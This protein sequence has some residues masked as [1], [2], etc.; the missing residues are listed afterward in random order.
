MEFLCGR[1]RDQ[2]PGRLD[3]TIVPMPWPVFGFPT[4][5]HLPAQP[6]VVN[7]RR[8]GQASAVVLGVLIAHGWLIGPPQR[9]LGRVPTSTQAIQ[10]VT[11]PAA[12]A[13]KPAPE[14]TPAPA[15][16]PAPPRPR[17]A[18]PKTPTPP[19]E[20]VTPPVP[21]P[22]P[23][24]PIDWAA[25]PPPPDPV[26]GSVVIPNEGIEADP[27]APTPGTVAGQQE[28]NGGRPP[29]YTTRR[30][31][32]AS[33]R[34]DYRVERGDDA[35]HAQLSY[36]LRTGGVFF[37]HLV[38]EAKGKQLV[39]QTSRGFFNS[40][41]FAPQR[42]TERLRGVDVS[43]VNF[44]RDQGVITFS[45]ST[46]AY[47]LYPG[48]QDR[49]S[50]ILQLAAIAQAEPGGLGP[51]QHIRMQVAGLRGTA[52]DWDFEVVGDEVV[53]PNGTPI[54]VVHLRREPTAPYDLRVEVWL[55]REAGHLPVGLRYTPV[56]G[57]FSEAYWLSGA[58]PAPPPASAP[59]RP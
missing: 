53:Q 49:I 17:K 35:G 55:A 54:P 34:L 44:Q 57:K 6:P 33:F 26:A 40:S 9:P 39:D 10:L 37:A 19:A 59:A 28:D 31:D 58:L 5:S 13:P 7:W 42:M 47:A 30:P 46:R 4:P 16:E 38:G 20:P 36:E 29:T 41:G 32:Q 12:E 50:M 56:P 18:Q 52:D 14:V 21:Q 1:G 43:A 22:P 3:G 15:A 25:G 8:R 2:E 48:T 24:T 51:G 45:S 23:D 11:L 27:T